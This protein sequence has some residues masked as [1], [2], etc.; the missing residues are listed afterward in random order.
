[1]SYKMYQVLAQVH[2]AL[3]DLTTEP[4]HFRL[5]GA[6]YVLL[7]TRG[8]MFEHFLN[9]FNQ[10]VW[11]KWLI[12]FKFPNRM[13]EN[14]FFLP[15]IEQQQQKKLNQSNQPKMV[16]PKRHTTEWNLN[17]TLRNYSNLFQVAQ[18]VTSV[19]C[20]RK[21]FMNFVCFLIFQGLVALVMNRID[22]S[23]NASVSWV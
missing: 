23:E 22:G 7:D 11:L 12:R 19:S 4:S 9:F 8:K 1:M 20:Y 13:I 5:V 21:I 6:F 10:H 15:S 16:D 18:K 14:D 17:K 2:D 3:D